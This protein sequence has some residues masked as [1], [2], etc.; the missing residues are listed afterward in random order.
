MDA[1]KLIEELIELTQ[2][3]M[4]DVQALKALTDEQ[5]NF[6]SNAESWSILE[7]I[8]HLNRYGEFY[9][10]EITR[11]LEQSKYPKSSKF[12]AGVLGNYF[13]KLMLPKEGMKKMKTF[14]EMNPLNSGLGRDVLSKF[15]HQQEVMLQLLDKAKNKD[16]TKIRTSISISKWIKLRLGDTFRVVIYHNQRHIVQAKHIY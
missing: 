3:N 14:S 8:E 9:I 12:K 7:C 6:K 4:N 5:L 15:I 16:L 2:Q 11:R 10:P 13:S 1:A